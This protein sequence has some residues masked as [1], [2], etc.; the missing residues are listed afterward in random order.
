MLYAQ[1][2]DQSHDEWRYNSALCT[3]EMSKP[4]QTPSLLSVCSEKHHQMNDMCVQETRGGLWSRAYD[5]LSTPE[6]EW[7]YL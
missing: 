3:V 7:C 1:D 4:K 6:L 2:V 5:R